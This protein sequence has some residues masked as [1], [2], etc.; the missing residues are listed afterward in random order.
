MLEFYV[1]VNINKKLI[2][3]ETFLKTK[4]RSYATS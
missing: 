3:L 4:I 1:L 2:R